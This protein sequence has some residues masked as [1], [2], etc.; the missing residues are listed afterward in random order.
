M[1]NGLKKPTVELRRVAIIKNN[2]NRDILRS[3]ADLRL[4]VLSECG[5]NLVE[6]RKRL[7]VVCID[8]R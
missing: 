8:C 2:T 7:E 3:S 4:K 1:L 5:F 6:P